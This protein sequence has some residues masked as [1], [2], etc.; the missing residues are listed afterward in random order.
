MEN[1]FL[2]KWPRVREGQKLQFR[3]RI[4]LFSVFLLISAA[5]WLLNALSKNYTS[6]IEYPLVYTDFPEDKVKV[7][8]MPGHLQLQINAHGYALLRYKMFRKPVPIS[9]KVSA[10]NLNRRQDSSSAYI[11]TRYLRDEIA[12]QLPA[13][14]Q[15]LGIQPDTLHFRFA[16]SVTR[17]VKIRP[18]FTYTI[19]KQFTIKDEIFLS[20]DSVEVTGPDLFLDTLSYVYTDR[21]DLGVLTRNFSDKVR[22]KK[23]PD[24]KYNISRVNC[25]IELE[26][27][28]E[29]QVTVPIEVLNLP[30][31]ILLQTFPSNVKLNCKVGLS[32]YDRI[33]SYPFR[34]V[35]DYEKIDE[36]LTSL[37][38]TIQNLPNY[39]LGYEY[40]PRTVEY[41]KF[42]K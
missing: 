8:E 20:P 19:E 33:E 2:Q 3:K 10:F 39:L 30:D 7:G 42:R 15:L 17:M 38:V 28:T 27:F 35:V 11:L 24:L 6:V 9:F 14:L 23:Q 21:Y 34:A 31:S 18:D 4:L 26:R 16:E 41:L 37:S 36:R 25:S 13:E 5:I 1:G 32:K 40:Y 22:L 12:R 29:L